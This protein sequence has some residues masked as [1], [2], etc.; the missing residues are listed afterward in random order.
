MKTV[1]AI[2]TASFVKVTPALA[3]KWLEN[4]TDNRHQRGAY[5]EA[6]AAAMRRGEWQTTHQG[7]AFAK[8]GKLLDGQ[9]RLEAIVKAK[10]DLDMLVVTG[11]EDA[12]FSVIDVGTKRS[13][14]DTTRLSKRSAEVCR[15]VVKKLLSS[16]TPTA[17]QVSEFANLGADR[18]HEKLTSYCGSTRAYYSSAPMR[19]AAVTLLLAGH[20]EDAVHTNYANLTLEKFS[21]MNGLS[22]SFVRLVNSGKSPRSGNPDLYA[23]GLKVLNPENDKMLRLRMTED[24][25]AA[26]FAYGRSVMKRVIAGA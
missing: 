16:Y 26:S 13:M 20:D 22:Q 7:V 17:A 15:F 8:C 6:I 19:A 11:L 5:I 3:A 24:D 18:L 23:Y 25:L 12:A 21:E 10:I 4:N 2:K 9:H 14:A 1:S